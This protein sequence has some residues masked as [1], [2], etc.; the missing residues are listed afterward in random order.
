LL[1]L[2]EYE[3][4]L[5]AISLKDTLRKNKKSQI[6]FKETGNEFGV[7]AMGLRIESAENIINKIS[8]AN[9]MF[10]LCK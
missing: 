5:L 6:K 7:S 4:M 10:D 2:T 9:K 3:V 8:T 1:D